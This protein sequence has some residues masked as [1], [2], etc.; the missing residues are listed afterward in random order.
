MI[1][2]I[3]GNTL[4]SS[5]YPTKE[6]NQKSPS[7]NGV[8]T[9]ICKDI[10]KQPLI[11]SLFDDFSLFYIFKAWM[12]KNKDYAAIC[13]DFILKCTN[14]KDFTMSV[15]SFIENSTGTFTIKCPKDKSVED[16]LKQI[17]ENFANK[18]NLDF[19]FKHQARNRNNNL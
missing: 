8:A 13:Q 17:V 3:Q 5:T 2:K 7:F 4:L 16:G 1:T 11:S 10:K 15:S 6:K 12:K 14:K 9:I 19:K 18:H